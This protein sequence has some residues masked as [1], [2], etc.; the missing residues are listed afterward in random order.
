MGIRGDDYIDPYGAPEYYCNHMILE[1]MLPGAV[2]GRMLY[3]R[4]GETIL[5]C[6]LIMPQSLIPQNIAVA[7]SFMSDRPMTAN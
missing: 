6:T 7:H 1:S 3:R 2:W 4:N 5:R